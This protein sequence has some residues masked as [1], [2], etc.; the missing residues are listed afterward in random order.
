M[1]VEHKYLLMNIMLYAIYFLFSHDDTTVC[2]FSCCR[3]FFQQAPLFLAKIL[4]NKIVVLFR[5][6]FQ[7]FFKHK[8]IY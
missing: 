6:F 2:P 5:A 4:R 3:S 1:I 7:E 8:K